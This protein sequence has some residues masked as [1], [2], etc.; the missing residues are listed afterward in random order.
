MSETFEWMS[1][2]EGR[3]RFSGGI[4]G[5]DEMGHDTFAVEVDQTEVFGEI[6]P[7]WLDDKVHFN[8]HITHFGYLDQLQVGMPLPSF[9][10]RTFTLEELERVK[11]LINR[12]VAAGLQLEDRPSVLMESKKS[13]FTGQVVFEQDWAL[14]TSAHS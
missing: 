9:S 7:K 1:F 14:A 2:P 5:F 3:A 10:T 12:L 8:V 11:L 4:R 6:E 13:L